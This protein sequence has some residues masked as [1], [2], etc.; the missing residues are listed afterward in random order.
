MDCLLAGGPCRPVGVRPA[1]I[2]PLGG[3]GQLINAP[4]DE[5]SP[6]PVPPLPGSAPPVPPLPGSAPPVPGSPVAAPRRDVAPTRVTPAAVFPTRVTPAAAGAA[7]PTAV[8]ATGAATAA[9]ASAAMAASAA[10]PAGPGRDHARAERC[11]AVWTR[12]LETCSWSGCGV[13]RGE[14]AEKHRSGQRASTHCTSGGVAH[15]SQRNHNS[16]VPS[17]TFNT[18]TQD[19]TQRTHWRTIA[20][21]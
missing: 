14:A 20:N 4:Q 10:A 21:S 9:M 15:R 7:A 6:P 16:R 18:D 1:W 13:R 3:A 17:K 12:S 2:L 5:G 8:A 11:A 19:V